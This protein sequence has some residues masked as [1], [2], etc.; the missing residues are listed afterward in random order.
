MAVGDKD[1]KSFSKA[2]E[3]SKAAGSRAAAVSG[4][5]QAKTQTDYTKT[6]AKTK[7]TIDADIAN[8]KKTLDLAK[9]K[10]TADQKAA[11]KDFYDTLVGLKPMLDK[12][13]TEASNVYKGDKSILEGDT[14][15]KAQGRTGVSS[16]GKYYVDGKEVSAQ[17][18]KASA[19]GTDMTGGMDEDTP[20]SP[21]SGATPAQVQADA[22]RRDAFA[23]LKDIFAQ[24][25]LEDLASTIEGYMKDDIGVNQATLLLKQTPAY[26]TRFSGNQMR[27]KAGLNVLSEAE[28]LAL[29]N[30]YSETLRAYGQAGYFG[31]DR[32]ARQAK[33]AAAIGADISAVE[34]KDRISTV[35]DRVN[36]AD[37]AVKSTLRSFYNITDEDLVGY[38]LN[39]KENL[40]RLKEKVTSAEIGATAF[41]QGL[42]SNVASAEELAKYGVD[43]ETARKGYATIADILPTATKLGDIYKEEGIQ[44]TQGTAEE[45]TFKGLASAQRKRQRLAEKEIASFSGQSGVTRGSLSTGTSGLI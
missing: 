40:P 23:L 6:L 4:K 33:L 21:T 42:G 37:P 19:G 8:A 41:A 14:A 28:Y 5:A 31:T 16:T 29:E 22:E 30:S 36:N 1:T 2:D 32:V 43:L 17:E 12:L 11:A 25:G 26:Q 45:E 18:Y 27:L 9:K 15:F 13:G 7:S 35:V 38:F 24:Y 44:Y 39:P 10:G 20:L 3:Q 34:F